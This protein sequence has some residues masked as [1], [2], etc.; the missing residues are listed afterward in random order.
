VAIAAVV[1][2]LLYHV[3]SEPAGAAP[4]IDLRVLLVAVAC[5][6]VVSI[7]AALLPLAGARAIDINATLRDG[8]AGATHRSSRL[9]GSLAAAQV[10]LA[11][12]LLVASGLFVHT[13]HAVFAIDLG[14]EP[15]GVLIARVDLASAGRTPEEVDRFYRAAL[16]RLQQLPAV[17]VASI[18]T[19]VP[20]SSGLAVYLA[21]PGGRSLLEQQGS[22][23]WVNLVTPEFFRSL[24]MRIVQG[25]GFTSAD[26]AGTER[27][28]VVARVL[29]GTLWP[30]ESPIGK[31]L[32]VS[33]PDAP[34]TRVVGVSADAA[35]DR[36]TEPPPL[37]YFMP[38]DQNVS[39]ATTR[40]LFV[41]T[42]L[43]GTAAAPAVRR[44]LETL[45]S[46]VPYP[47]IVSLSS[48]IEPHVR[49]WRTAAALFTTFAVIAVVLAVLGLQTVVAYAVVERRR[50]L[51]VRL[52]LGGTSGRILGFVL[53][54]GLRTTAIGLAV[55][56][57][58]AAVV[59]A[60]A[61]PLLFGTSTL[62]PMAYGVAGVTLLVC[63]VVA[64]S[65]PAL[66]AL[67]IAPA[68]ALRRG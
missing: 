41:K 62:E 23:P 4:H 45:D 16:Q 54:D 49:P 60:K 50:E 36:P 10:A 64:C 25:R 3:I 57:S 2:R 63:S 39:L 20:F 6:G 43:S 1:N 5:T 19:T 30:G 59:T 34:C 21:L 38:L 66:R 61:A 24:G 22:V 26:R 13:L 56:L 17:E 14:M 12:L 8:S 31:C 37:Q 55:G 27:V 65:I 46:D 32:E 33:S 35:R 28:A 68:D 15:D 29:A 18:G 47:V 48:L 9:R 44:A 58:A 11:A 40:A 52:A 42:R 67:S 51:A 7:I 53:A